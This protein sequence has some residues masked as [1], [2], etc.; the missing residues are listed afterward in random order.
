MDHA[1]LAP[2]SANRW[3]N[4][5][6]SVTMEERYPERTESESAREGTAGHWVGSEVL[7]G[8]GAESFVGRTAPNGVIITEEMVDAAKVYVE[9]VYS[10]APLAAS[11]IFERRVAITRVHPTECFGTP[12]CRYST[13]GELHVWDYKYGYGIVEPKENWQLICYAAGYMDE[14]T[15]IPAGLF[16]Q[17]LTVNLHIVQPRPFH[18]QGSCRTW[19]IAGTDLRGYI[20][21]LEAAATAAL[22]PNPQL[23]SGDH[24]RYCSARHACPAAQKAALF[25]IDYSCGAIP[26][27]LSARALGIEYRTLQRAAEAIKYRLTGLEQQIIQLLQKGQGSDT[28]FGIQHGKGRVQWSVPAAE[29]FSLGDLMGKDLRAPL[30]PITPVQAQKLGLPADV[31]NAYTSTPENGIKLVPSGGTLAA[32]VFG[33]GG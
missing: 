17:G 27:E 19:R 28:G 5:P 29:V 30:S 3:V 2:S 26:E 15:E 31:L 24:C 14:L 13:P 12:D 32:Q 20:N 7:V 25:A 18:Q 22:G 8:R 6:G 16:D 10:I 4:C 1:R 33:Q 9:H 11:R 21:R 23:Q